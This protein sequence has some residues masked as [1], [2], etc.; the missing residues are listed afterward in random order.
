MKRIV[1]CGV[2]G[3]VLV[4][5]PGCSGPDSL[6]RELIVHLN[7]YAETVEK[8]EPLDKQLAA[9]ERA[10][11]TYGKIEKLSTEDRDKLLKKF[12]SDWKKVRDRIDTALKN[13][14]MEGGAASPNVMDGF[15]K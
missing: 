6:M 11:T 10:R 14:S 13:Q 5:A 1:A 8:K 12:D 2:L 9:F 4:C 7:A 15:F 3:V